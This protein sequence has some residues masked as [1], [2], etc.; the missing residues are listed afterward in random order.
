M[1]L[2]RR[3]FLRQTGTLALGAAGLAA[4]GS[5]TAAP[6]NPARR[7]LFRAAQLTDIH[8]SA[9]NRAPEGM[10]AALRHAQGQADKPD[11]LL[12]TGDCIG[13]ALGTPKERVLRQWE[14]WDRIVAAEVRTPARCVIGNHDIFGWNLRD[15]PAVTADPA[16]GKTLALQHL[17]LKE[18][19]YS[20]EQSGWHFVVLDSM[21][22]DHSNEQGYIAR[23]DDAQFTWLRADLA[24]TPATTP[25]CVLS[26]IPILSLAAFLDGNNSRTGTWVV[27]GAW[28]HIDAR[29]IKDLFKL[30][31][32]VKVCLSGH[33]HM[34]EDATYLGVRYLCNGAVSGGWWKGKHQEFGPAYA[35]IDFY[36]DGSVENQM[37]GYEY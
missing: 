26:H 36:D 11:L 14:I 15:N 2:H 20:F 29:R 8:V 16:Y 17:G 13:D 10:T 18:R 24:A 22:R 35:L 19:Y 31:P 3:H 21:A 23:L 25:V 33:L 30:H 7:R 5:A 12:F 27:P 9:E 6:V 34:E 32:N 1:N 37:V 28:M 4:V